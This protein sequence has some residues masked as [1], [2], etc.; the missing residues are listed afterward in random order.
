M[1][2]WFRRVRS[3]VAIRVFQDRGL[4]L[5]LLILARLGRAICQKEPSQEDHRPGDQ[6]GHRVVELLAHTDPSREGRYCNLRAWKFS[7]AL[8]KSSS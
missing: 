7:G 6:E 1:T 2:P 8:A 4:P 3:T 5:L